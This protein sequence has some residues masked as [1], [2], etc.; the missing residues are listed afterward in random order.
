MAIRALEKI[1]TIDKKYEQVSSNLKSIYY[2]LQE[3]SR[4]ISGYEED[5]LMNKKEII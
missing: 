2:E 1:E 4:D 5:T 3:I